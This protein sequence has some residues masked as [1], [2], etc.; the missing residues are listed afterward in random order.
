MAMNDPAERWFGA[1][2]GQLQYF[3]WIGLSHAWTVEQVNINGDLSRGFNAHPE[4]DSG[5]MGIFNK[6]SNKI[7]LSL[8]TIPLEDA[9]EIRN[10]ERGN[11]LKQ[12]AAKNHKKIY[13]L[14]RI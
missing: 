2:T 3:G 5:Q 8:I 6:L 14:N 1:I 7:W 4:N 10:V 12:R 9:Q 11:L 13:K